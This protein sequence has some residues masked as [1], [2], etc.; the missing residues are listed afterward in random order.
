MAIQ[1]NGSKKAKPK[2]KAKNSEH[3]HSN[4]V[5]S[6]DSLSDSFIQESGTPWML[7]PGNCTAFFLPSDGNAF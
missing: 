6:P 2:K 5:L 7:S 3:S 1:R 4:E